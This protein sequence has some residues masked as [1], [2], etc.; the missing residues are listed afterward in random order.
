MATKTILDPIGVLSVK[1]VGGTKGAKGAFDLL[2]SKLPSLKGR[3]FYGTYN[4]WTEEY[5]A[6]VVKTQGEDA[7]RIGLEEWTIPGGAYLTRKI[8]DWPSKMAEL[9]KM[10]DELAAGQKV[11]TS[12]PSLEFYR[13]DRELV[14]YLPIV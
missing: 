9:P 6:C 11:D 1:A 5:R 7:S 8:D 10:F 12:R 2:E 4:P 3:R 13:S 14:L